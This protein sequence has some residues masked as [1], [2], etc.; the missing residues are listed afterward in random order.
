MMHGV[1]NIK[2]RFLFSSYPE[3]LI[4]FVVACWEE[5]LYLLYVRYNKR[6]SKLSSRPSGCVSRFF[7]PVVLV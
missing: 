1:T 3:T 2:F 7:S 6:R 5:I 4:S